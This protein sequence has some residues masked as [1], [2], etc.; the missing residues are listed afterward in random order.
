MPPYAHI[1]F[2]SDV[3]TCAPPISTFDGEIHVPVMLGTQ[4]IGVSTPSAAA[5]AEATVG[6]ASEVQFPNGAILT[7]GAVSVM[8]ATGIPPARPF[9]CEVTAASE[10]GAKPKVHWSDAPAVTSIAVSIRPFRSRGG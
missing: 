2:A 1:H 9:C 10:P 4:G 7:I 6:F 3:S 5:V 8:V